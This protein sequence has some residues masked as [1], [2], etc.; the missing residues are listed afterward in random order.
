MVNKKM[1]KVF[2]IDF[3]RVT[4]IDEDYKKL[5]DEYLE[6]KRW[7]SVFSIIIMKTYQWLEDNRFD[8]NYYINY[9]RWVNEISN[10]DC[11]IL[12]TL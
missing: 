2:I 8:A 1:K 7:S 6:T 12:A 10:S 5:I 11:K 9:Y 4:E 3:G